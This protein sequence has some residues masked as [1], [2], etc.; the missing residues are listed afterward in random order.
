MTTAMSE[1][2]RVNGSPVRFE[3][4]GKRYG[5]FVAVHPM[6]LQVGA[7]EFLSFLGPSG[8]GKTTTLMMLAGF[9]AP[10]SGRILVGDRDITATA[11][12]RR[13]I[14]MVFQSYAL[15]PHMTVEQN[16]AF[17]LRMRRM[18]GAE[19]S[20]SVARVLEIVGLGEFARRY[21]AQLS[22]GQQ[23][24]VALARA[25]VFQP[26]VLL[27]D[28]PLS[29]LDKYLRSHLQTEIKR[30][31]RELGITVVYVTHD[32]DEAMTLSDR[33][34]V[35]RDGRIAQIGAPEELYRAPQDEFVAGFL[36]ESNMFTRAATA[37]DGGLRLDLGNG[38]V[39]PV[40]QHPAG[41]RVTV[42]VRPEH[43][44]FHPDPAGAATVRDATYVGDHRRYELALDDGTV[45][46]AKVQVTDGSGAVAPGTRVAVDWPVA[47]M[48]L[49]ADGKALQ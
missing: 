11:P 46:V 29:A 5:S 31:Q 27:M 7:G 40:A 20:R 16:I 19:R 6:D 3:G 32:Q 12:A 49:F 38:L 8:S 47:E 44:R 43:L 4:L 33:I 30:I 28:E 45:L 48:R 22:G 39:L 18:A 34:C 26:P 35:M 42:S 10:T 41:G 23:Q 25:I 21:P 13:D 17:P 36:G 37:V 14:G 1:P 2:A 15:F 9:E 24:R